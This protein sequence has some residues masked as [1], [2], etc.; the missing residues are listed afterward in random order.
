MS[1]L[2]GRHRGGEVLH[3]LP[4]TST[5]FVGR[6]PDVSRLHELT[7]AR[8]PVTLVG[9]AGAGK[10]RL[11]VEG[12]RDLIPDHPGGVWFAEMAGLADGSG[13][14]PELARATNVKQSSGGAALELVCGRLEAAQA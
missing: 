14:A 5:D 4:V 9:T 7:H 6:R 8:R 12:A 11:A 10:T 2:G 3:N 13:V 1:G